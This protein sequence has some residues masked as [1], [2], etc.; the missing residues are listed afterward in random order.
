METEE[1]Q[2]EKLKAWLKENG[3]SIVFGIVIGV[4]GIGGYNYWVHVQETTAAKASG[5]FTQMIDA[6]AAEDG[7]GLQEQADILI[8]DHAST[9]YALLAHLALAR[10]HVAN[11]DFEQAEAALQQVV[12][13]AAQR[14]LAY[15]ARIRLAAVQLQTEQFEK[16]LTTLAIEFPAQFAALADELR[17][18]I[19]AMQ[20]KGEEAIE[21]YRKAQLAEPKPANVEFL[22]QKLND[23]GSA[24]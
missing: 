10:N 21:A 6:L 3:L 20:G 5:H 7:E 15:V 18:D 23:L 13:S 12:G 8:T 19:F 4:G 14:P 22:R 24:S 9:D 17:G 1:E 2:V 16:A 11:A